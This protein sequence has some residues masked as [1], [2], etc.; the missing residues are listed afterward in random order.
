MIK[1]VLVQNNPIFGDVSGNIRRLRSLL[2]TRKE[3]FP[4]LL[5]LPELFASGYQFTSR[6]EAMDLSESGGEDGSTPGQTV[7]FLNELS[8]E[9][10]GWVVGGLPLRRGERVFNSSIVSFKGMIRAVYDKTHLFEAENRWFDPGEGPLCLVDTPFGKLGVMICFDWLF[11]EVSRSLALGGAM[12]IAHPVNW[13]LPFGPQGMILRSV[14]NRV[15]TVTANRVGEESR[16]G[17]PALRYIGSSQI[18]SPAGE[19]V[20]RASVS[21]E[22]I[23]ERSID[24]ELARDKKVVA[25][26][27]FFRQRRPELYST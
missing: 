5:V 18:V 17:L 19:I 2:A 21:S 16:G 13:V 9:T 1:V 8:R 22:E 20:A 7:S 11:P 3:S 25:E 15:F 6:K 14:E 23:L 4:D 26:S 10:G 12:V 24:P 27:D